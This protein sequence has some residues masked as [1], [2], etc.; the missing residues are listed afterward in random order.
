MLV[1]IREEDLLFLQKLQHVMRTQDT[2]CQA[3]PRYWTIMDTEQVYNVTA[4]DAD[5]SYL[6]YCGNIVA[7]SLDEIK[8]FILDMRKDIL[9]KEGY[10]ELEI[11]E[12]TAPIRHL[13]VYMAD[14]EYEE[15]MRI[16]D[17]EDAAVFLND[18]FESEN[19]DVIYAKKVQKPAKGPLFMTKAAAEEY[20]QK[21]GYNHSKDAHPYAMTAY[22]SPEIERLWKI[23]EETSWKQEEK[24]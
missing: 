21:Y 2:C 11:T 20:L 5:E 17:A 8:K 7:K 13:N 1:D 4:F 24:I 23:V 6:T 12:I 22:R 18:T 3:A 19:Y 16:D 10:D 9:K 14:S 15:E